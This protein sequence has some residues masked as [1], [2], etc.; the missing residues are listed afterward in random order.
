MKSYYLLLVL[1][2]LITNS[3][4]ADAQNHVPNHSF[5]DNNNCP[6]AA[7]Q[8][9]YCNDWKAVVGTP[10][11]F[12]VCGSGDCGVPNN[13]YAMNGYVGYQVPLHGDAY[14]GFMPYNPYHFEYISASILPLT[15]GQ[16]YEVSMSVSLANWSSIA[17][18][19]IGVFFYDKGYKSDPWSVSDLFM[20]MK[21]QVHY[22]SFG[23]V[24]DTAKWVRLKKE[25]IPDSAYSNIMI[26]GFNDSTGSYSIDTV[27]TMVSYGVGY[28]LIDSVVI[29]PIYPTSV[30]DLKAVTNLDFYPNPNNGRFTL[31]GNTHDE[32]L[33]ITILN[34]M[35]QVVYSRTVKPLYGTLQEEVKIDYAAK[36]MYL[37]LVTNTS[38]NLNTMK[39]MIE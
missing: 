23:I 6:T 16:R 8:A 29:R 18:D 36:G 17:T 35:G 20:H 7:M 1:L 28:Y 33:Q 15:P 2:P 14:M 3:N 22:R 34:T 13:G 9:H 31:K 27:G 39:F 37:L 32:T 4:I 19:N 26:G 5:E 30:E 11:Y 24:R 12:N 25:Y 10:D 21:P 38:G